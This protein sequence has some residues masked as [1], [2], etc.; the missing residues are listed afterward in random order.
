MKDSFL[1][2]GSNVDVIRSS[3][4]LLGKSF[5]GKG[6]SSEIYDGG[7]SIF[8]LSTDG[9]SHTFVILAAKQGLS[10]PQC[11][12]DWGKVMPSDE[13][14]ELDFYWL[15][16]FEKLHELEC[17]PEALEEVKNWVGAVLE[18]A[19]V[20]SNLVT[21]RQELGRVY[22][23]IKQLSVSERLA[24]VKAT[25]NFMCVQ[26]LEAGADLD[27]NESNFMLRSATGEILVT[28]PAHGL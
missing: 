22:S 7:D 28:D 2:E 19:E 8:R 11:L 26:C 23:A 24:P 10:V 21:D 15:G 25:M 16:E 4:P 14:P 3:G 27:F 6:S 12:N 13:Y 18:F 5:I 9:A 17:C 20:D 1:F